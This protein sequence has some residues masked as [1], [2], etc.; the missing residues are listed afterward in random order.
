MEGFMGWGGMF[1]GPLV[2]LAVAGLVIAGFVM[3]FR[4]LFSHGSSQD[5]PVEIL[6]TRLARGEIDKREYEEQ[7]RTLNG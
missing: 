6:K 2:M 4:M 5:S 1:F 7:F 3:L